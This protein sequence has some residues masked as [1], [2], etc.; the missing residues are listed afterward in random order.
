[1][2]MRSAP[3]RLLSCLLTVLLIAVFVA[4]VPLSSGAADSFKWNWQ[5]PLPQGNDLSSV[6]AADA[7]HAWAVGR[8]GT[9]LFFNGSVWSRRESP[10]AVDLNDVLA[11]DRTHVWAVGAEGTVIFFNGTSW[12]AQTS[13]TNQTLN[14]IAGLDTTHVWAVG[15]NGTILFFNGVSWS[16]QAS[17][18]SNALMSITVCD[19][20][21]VWAA[22]SAGTILFFDGASWSPQ[23][24]GASDGW[25]TGISAADQA[26]IWA[27]GYRQSGRALSYFLLFY[28]G[29]A[30]S[31]QS[32]GTDFWLN[33]VTA[34]DANDVWAVGSEGTIMRFRDGSWNEQPGLTGET[35]YGVSALDG[36]HV[37]AVGNAGVTLFSNGS[38]I[39]QSR[40]VTFD[41]KAVASLDQSCTWA[42]GESS[43]ILYDD[44]TGWTAQ[45][46]GA[47]GPFFGITA[48]DEE[49]AWAVGEKGRIVFW[50]GTAWHPQ[51]SG[52]SNTLYSVT[53]ADPSHVWAVGGN[54]TVRFFNGATWRSQKSGTLQRLC[55][56]SAADRNN[57]WAVGAGKIILYYDGSTWR[58]AE[59]TAAGGLNAVSAC[60]SGHVWAVGAD[61]M[62]VS[63]DGGLSWKIQESGTTTDLLGVHAC[64]A[65]RVWTVGKGGSVRFFD[66]GAWSEQFSGSLHNLTC[67]SAKA[68]GRVLVAGDAGNI[69]AGNT[70]AP[71]TSRVWGTD[72]IGA[73]MPSKTW[74]LAE[75]STGT[76]FESW[77]L[78]QNPNE[79]A[80]TVA[81]DYLTGAGKVGG[82]TLNL[83]P[84][85]RATVNI[86][87]TLPDTWSVST[88]IKSNRP[89]VAERAMYGA[90]RT[91]GHDSIGAAEPAMT[92]YLAEGSTGPG[93][94]TWILVENPGDYTAHVVLSFMTSGAS[95]KRREVEVP[96]N[97]RGTYNVA[98]TVPDRWSVS[99]RVQSDR[100]VVAER[101]M[102]GSNR[103]WAHDSV[104][105][106][107]AATTWYLAEGSTGP[108]FETWILV[109]NPNT[110]PTEIT[111]SYLTPGGTVAQTVDTLAGNSRKT[112]SVGDVVPDTWEVSTKVKGEGPIVAE[113]A[114][115][116][117]GRVWAHD[118]IGSSEAAEDWYLA[119]GSTGE[120]FETWVL[121]QNPGGEDAVVRLHYM[122]PGG[123]IEGPIARVPA[124]SRMTFNV[125]ESVPD[126]S[127]VSTMVE[128]SKPVIAE[129]AVYGDSK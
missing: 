34:I 67:V 99:T 61:G 14:G 90:G 71:V 35:L 59:T 2:V 112:Y 16:Q 110:A 6:S 120:G 127:S 76:G 57:V 77:V 20:A 24:G 83:P 114:M 12:S 36:G 27:A 33:D 13:Q 5:N 32:E 70:V 75:G 65:N 122:T 69:L 52:T 85:S 41:I 74:Y 68:G 101:A 87:D 91:W 45:A 128:S 97:S 86:A 105:V 4:L 56:V 79:A 29:S 82:P 28:D 58:G 8:G 129:R 63:I 54:G 40:G 94:E 50:D 73:A 48:L 38:W 118:S 93:F 103:T 37:W 113:R 22:G 10:T 126:E 26:H 49:H 102:Y 60:D 43:E 92:W 11:L 72:S 84:G 7:A 18:S 25:I 124:L 80:A 1:M 15:A 17:G 9:I 89:V 42:V 3:A 109:Q 53:A 21:H 31:I 23:P 51:E 100:P 119:E 64:S 39:A 78:V 30:W 62:V 117:N 55:G 121:V 106:T 98:D 115:Y 104:G 96:A 88:F 81:L 19:A 107:E 111:I 66:G 44:G 46:S 116:G 108:G 123:E 95:V 125:G 47:P